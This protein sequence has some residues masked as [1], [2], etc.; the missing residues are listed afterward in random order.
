MRAVALDCLIISLTLGLMTVLA[1]ALRPPPLFVGSAGVTVLL[2][3]LL[4][5][6]LHKDERA[7]AGAY[8]FLDP[9]LP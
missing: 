8:D 5:R 7:E 6:R 9:D 3:V 2:S 4:L 1:V